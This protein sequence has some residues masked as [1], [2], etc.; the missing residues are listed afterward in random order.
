MNFHEMYDIIIDFFEDVPQV[1][2]KQRQQ[3][4]AWWNW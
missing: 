2:R 3:L 1:K 4:L